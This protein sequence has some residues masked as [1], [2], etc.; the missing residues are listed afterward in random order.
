[1]KKLLFILAVAALAAGVSAD[2]LTTKSGKVY[3]S[4]AIMGAAPNGILIFHENGKAVIPVKEF[5]DEY[6]EK[7]AKYEKEI[8]AKKR[9]AAQKKALR[10][11]QARQAAAE[12]KKREAERKARMKKFLADEEARKKK[13]KRQPKQPVQKQRQNLPMALAE[14]HSKRTDLQTGTSFYLVPHFRDNTEKAPEFIRTPE[15][16]HFPDCRP[17]RISRA[18]SNPWT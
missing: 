3:K 10:A 13:R 16:F 8:P 6:K 2:D 9:E 4:F 18:C 7:I 14:I 11:K 1:M 17:G 5:P 15:L 12:K